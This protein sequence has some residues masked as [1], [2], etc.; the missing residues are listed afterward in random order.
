MSVKLVERERESRSSL[1]TSRKKANKRTS[2]IGIRYRKQKDAKSVE[3]I[4]IFHENVFASKSD[5]I[6]LFCIVGM[7]RKNASTVTTS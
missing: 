1:A 5:F 6:L 3:I 2:C 4:Y 7:S